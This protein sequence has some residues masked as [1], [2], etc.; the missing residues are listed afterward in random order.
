MTFLTHINDRELHNMKKKYAPK[1]GEN[2]RKKSKQNRDKQYAGEKFNV[3][4]LEILTRTDKSGG[5]H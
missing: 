1:R 3:M 5:S 4:V 2:D